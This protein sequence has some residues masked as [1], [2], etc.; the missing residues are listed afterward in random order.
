MT[1]FLQA[2]V[3]IAGLMVVKDQALL[4]LGLMLSAGEIPRIAGQFGLE[5]GTK[6]NVMVKLCLVKPGIIA[7]AVQS[8]QTLWKISAQ[9]ILI[10]YMV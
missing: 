4:G 3:L 5:T 10:L 7:S 9:S 6:A 8:W 1:A 2:T